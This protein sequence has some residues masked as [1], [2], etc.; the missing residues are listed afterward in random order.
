M[1][2]ALKLFHED[3]DSIFEIAKEKFNYNEFAV[4]CK[5]SFKLPIE[6]CLVAA[7]E[8]IEPFIYETETAVYVLSVI[9]EKTENMMFKFKIKDENFKNAIYNMSPGFQIDSNLAYDFNSLNW[10]E[11]TKF[12]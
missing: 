4:T 11:I 3:I 5:E 6:L 10:V 2:N 8:A 9:Q 7:K 1:E 12:K